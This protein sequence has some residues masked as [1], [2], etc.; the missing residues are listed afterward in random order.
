MPPLELAFGYLDRRVLLEVMACPSCGSWSVKADR[1]LAGRLVCGRCARPLGV[2]AATRRRRSRAGRR[3]PRQA[4]A[5]ALAGLVAMAALLA[6]FDQQRAR[7]S[8]PS[9]GPAPQSPPSPSGLL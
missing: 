4:F 9:G 5:M 3:Q 8:A 6:A 2:A 1:G 7:F